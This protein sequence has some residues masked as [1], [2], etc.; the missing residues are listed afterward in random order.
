[1]M[2]VAQGSFLFSGGP[3]KKTAHTEIVLIDGWG[4]FSQHGGTM[5]KT[6]QTGAEAFGAQLT[7]NPH[8]HQRIIPREHRSH[9]SCSG[10]EPRPDQ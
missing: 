7:P 10:G 1:M 4:R 8:Q 3:P 6:N 9:D 2:G 5:K